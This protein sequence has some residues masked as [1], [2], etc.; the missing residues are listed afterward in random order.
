MVPFLFICIIGHTHEK[1]A[2]WNA[3]V[4]LLSR[5]MYH[6]L[7]VTLIGCINK[8]ILL[9]YYSMSFRFVAVLFITFHD[10]TKIQKFATGRKAIVTISFE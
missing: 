4:E 2:K 6:V 1:I 3:S 5:Y 7:P 8:M 9:D 10:S